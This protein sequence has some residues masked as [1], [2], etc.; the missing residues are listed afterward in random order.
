MLGFDGRERAQR[1][2]V[3]ECH[4]DI[5]REAMEREK[6]SLSFN[7][8]EGRVPPNRF[9]HFGHGAHDECVKDASDVVFP[10]RHCRDVRLHRCVAVTLRNLWVSAGE[11]FRI[12]CSFHNRHLSKIIPEPDSTWVLSTALSQ[13]RMMYKKIGV[14]HFSSEQRSLFTNKW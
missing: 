7:A 8:V 9:L 13:L 1:R 14:T 10:A 12:A 3:K 4:F 5:L 2:A 6:P 11:K